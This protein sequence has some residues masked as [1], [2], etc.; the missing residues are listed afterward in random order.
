[1]KYRLSF[2]FGFF[3]LTIS[4]QNYVDIVNL[5]YANTLLN[6]FENSSEQTNVEDFGLQLTFPIVLN[7]KVVLLAGLSANNSRVKLN[8]NMPDYASLSRI[9]LQLG[10]NLVHSEK[11]TGT[12]VL[13]PN[14]SSDFD[15]ASKEDFQIGMLTI[16]TYAKNKNFKYK[17][18][19]YANTENYGPLISPL[20]GLYYISPNKKFESDLLLPGLFNINYQILKKTVLGVDFNAITSSYNLHKD[21]HTPEGKYVV[22]SSSELFAYLQFQFGKSLYARTK[23]GYPLGRTYKVFNENDK[24]DLSLSSIY[25]GDDRIQLNQ[26]FDRGPI[27]K[28]ELLYRIHF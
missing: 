1:M 17:I 10:L 13:L 26:N 20:L 28:I 18:G 3:F 27:F 9:R 8:Q 22:R 11:W 16:L 6:N 15:K 19:L 7:K 2:L 4:A 12:Y 23:V 24:V 25:F 5:S 14:I 21:I